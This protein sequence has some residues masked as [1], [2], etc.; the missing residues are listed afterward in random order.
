M[1]KLLPASV[2]AFAPRSTV[3]IV[4]DSGKVEPWLTQTLEN[5]YGVRRPLNSVQQHTRSLTKT[6][7]GSNAIWSLCSIM[8]P[9]APDAELRKDSNPLVEAIFNC[10]LIRIEAYVVHLDMVSQ[11]EVT[12]KL[13]TETIEALTEYHKDIYSVDVLASTWNWPEKEA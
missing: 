9:K 5:I 2:A 11:H 3:N 8:I 1:S 6:L 10:Q 4:L 7:S 13:T 12:F